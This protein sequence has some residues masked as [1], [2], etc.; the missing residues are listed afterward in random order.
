MTTTLHIT[1]KE[2]DNYIYQDF[3]LTSKSLAAATA[4]T[5]TAAKQMLLCLILTNNANMYIYLTTIC[6]YFLRS[7]PNNIFIL[8]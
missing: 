6:K 3:Q 5:D 1:A 7:T 2:E 8:L 4:T